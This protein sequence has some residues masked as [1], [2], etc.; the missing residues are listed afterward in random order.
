MIRTS[1]FSL[2]SLFKEC[3][4]TQSL[5]TLLF[6]SLKNKI[7]NNKKSNIFYEVPDINCPK[8][9]T[10]MSTQYLNIKLDGHDKLH[11]KCPNSA[12]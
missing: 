10:G 12:T 4:K 6:T 9:Y 11:K 3:H 8:K 7:P 1:S 2:H 5:I